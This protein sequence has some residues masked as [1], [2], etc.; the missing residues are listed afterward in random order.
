[1]LPPLESPEERRA[2]RVN[3]VVDVGEPVPEELAVLDPLPP[4]VQA[5]RKQ[6]ELAV[7]VAHQTTD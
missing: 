7:L 1:M 4:L 5:L 6:I 2:L 3:L